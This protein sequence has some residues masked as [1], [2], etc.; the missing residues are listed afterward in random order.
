V[1]W[2]NVAV[3]DGRLQPEVGFVGPRITEPAFVRAVDRELQRLHTFLGLSTHAD[4]LGDGA[5]AR[6]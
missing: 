4:P 6:A 5:P 2:A 1:G 3:R